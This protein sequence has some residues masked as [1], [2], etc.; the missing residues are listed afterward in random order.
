MGK[1]ENLISLEE[2]LKL[3]GISKSTFKQNTM[4]KMIFN[5]IISEASTQRI[6]KSDR[7]NNILRAR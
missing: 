4:N 2:V 3:I 5:Q 7:I 6:Y 1:S